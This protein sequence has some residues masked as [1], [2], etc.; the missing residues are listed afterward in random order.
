[1]HGRVPTGPNG[2]ASEGEHSPLARAV[3][4]EGPGFDGYFGQRGCN[5]TVLNGPRIVRDHISVTSQSLAPQRMAESAA[6]GKPHCA[7]TQRGWRVPWPVSSTRWIPRSW[8]AA[9]PRR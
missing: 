5:E 6:Q 3:R 2:L 8:C 9:E 1:M 4:D 7:A